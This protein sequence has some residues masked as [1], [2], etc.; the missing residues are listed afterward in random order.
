MIVFLFNVFY[1][2]YGAGSPS[3]PSFHD[4]MLST[5][6]ESA[7]QAQPGT[8][9]AQEYVSK[10]AYF[11]IE[12]VISAN[13]I[14]AFHVPF[15]PLWLPIGTLDTY[16]GV[17]VIVD[18]FDDYELTVKDSI[19]IT[20][21]NGEVIYWTPVL[22]NGQRASFK[23]DLYRGTETY[24]TYTV[25]VPAGTVV[26]ENGYAFRGFSWTFDII[27]NIAP[28][29]TVTDAPVDAMSTLNTFS[30]E[31][32]FS[33]EVTGVEEALKG[34]IGLDTVVT[35]DGIV[36]ELTFSGDDEMEGMLELI[37]SLV[38]DVS[39][40]ANKLV[41]GIKWPY[42]IGD[43]VAPTAVVE[44][45]LKSNP[46]DIKITFS[47]EVIVPVGGIVVNGGTATVTNVGN[48]YK[49]SVAANDGA[50]VKLNLTS[51]ITDNSKNANA[52]VAAEY[53][54]L[55]GDRTAPVADVYKP[56][57]TDTVPTFD[58]TIGFNEQVTGVN[59]QSVKVS[60]DGAVLKLRTI[61]EG[62]A[63]EATI[64][65]KEKTT[66]VLS[67]TNAIKDVAGNALVPVN[68]T[69]TIGDFSGSV[70]T[71]DPAS[72]NFITNMFEVTLTFDEVV[73]GVAGAV[74]VSGG[75]VS[76]TGSGM[77]YTA[78]IDAPSMS[79]VNLI[80]GT[81]IVDM[82]GNKFAGA[83]FSYNVTGLV[84]IATV[85]S[86]AS[87]SLHKGKILQ[88]EGT[89]TGVAAGEGFFVQDAVA[90]WSGIWVEYADVNE[91][92]IEVG[93]RVLVTGEVAEIADV[94][95]IIASDGIN[96]GPETAVEITAIEV[97]PTEAEAEKYESV[98]MKVNGARATSADAG[99][100]E[101]TIYYVPTNNITVNDWM[102]K[103]VPVAGHFYDVT[104][105]V[106]GRL[107]AF[108][109]EPRMES[110][111]VDLT[112]TGVNPNYESDFKVY[113][114]PFNNQITIDS[115]DKLTRVVISNIAGQRVIDIEYPNREINTANLVSGIYVISLYTESGIAKTERM[116]KK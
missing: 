66:V 35:A 58:V 114:N 14:E 96:Y 94:T 92:D 112:T 39:N 90:A 42:K 78:M 116:I 4:I 76:V 97:S 80:L 71:A 63:Y 82:A 40:N 62:R 86:N 99:S 100:G 36:Y 55:L 53:T 88:I 13:A 108:K 60:G 68:F 61:V 105:I 24:G 17:E 25:T 26:N 27:E 56:A 45:S 30:V 43:H 87:E 93:D 65:G 8:V 50:T 19:R 5:L 79:G 48:V 3:N 70:V 67:L 98:L 109:L 111:V 91:D 49:V 64:T 10:E 57:A 31:L 47:E 73:T 44:P 102:Y 23:P 89:V 106:N 18:F 110:D 104:G 34:S 81:T 75:T 21:P 41:G 28:T 72:G 12:D 54:Y 11:V 59:T 38:T 77:V 74:Q 7:T 33:E 115:N 9:N 6:D 1:Q 22:D 20:L 69:Y 107:D 103:A 15:L 2:A 32:T 16:V 29:V 52:L 37:D 95:T 101:W 113:P 84:P 85:Q 83:T 46:F 51:L